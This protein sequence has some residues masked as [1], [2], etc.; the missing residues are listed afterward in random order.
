MRI[1]GTHEFVFE[2]LFER[3]A[4]FGRL[5]GLLFAGRPM[6]KQLVARP[7]PSNPNQKGCP[8]TETEPFTITPA[9]AGKSEGDQKIVFFEGPILRI[10][11][12][13]GY[14]GCV[15]RSI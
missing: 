2:K 4:M 15:D 13:R 9:V 10:F 6:P 14:R 7:G 5:E 11:G 8:A 1:R 12:P 3:L